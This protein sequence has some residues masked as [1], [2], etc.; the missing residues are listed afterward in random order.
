[1]Q[2]SVRPGRPHPE[3]V[4]CTT[5]PFHPVP[6]PASPLPAFIHLKSIFLSSPH[7]LPHLILTITP[8]QVLLLSSLFRQ[9]NEGSEAS[10]NWVHITWLI[11]GEAKCSVP[12]DTLHL[13]T[14]TTVA[15][16]KRTAPEMTQVSEPVRLPG[17][18]RL[19]ACWDG[20]LRTAGCGCGLEWVCL[21]GVVCVG[22]QAGQEPSPTWKWSGGS[23]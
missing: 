13:R 8:R 12:V 7:I 10:N 23:W 2:D 4:L 18:P 20:S 17:E 3:S 21:V 6:G 19:P 1:M 15:S 9:G 5:L 22:G 16:S 14:Q 11:S